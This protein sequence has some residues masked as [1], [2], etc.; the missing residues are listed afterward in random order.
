MPFQLELKS[1]QSDVLDLAM[2]AFGKLDMRH[3][4]FDVLQHSVPKEV[5]LDLAHDLL[6]AKVSAIEAFVII[7]HYLGPTWFGH[8]PLFVRH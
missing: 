5:S 6:V 1:V 4:L 7:F 3:T 2:I 8:V